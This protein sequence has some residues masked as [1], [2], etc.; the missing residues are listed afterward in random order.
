MI[1][2]L[3][4]VGLMTET[5]ILPLRKVDA[6]PVAEFLQRRFPDATVIVSAS[7]EAVAEISKV[8]EQLDTPMFPGRTP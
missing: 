2:A 7:A 4:T 5:A 3:L 8:V 6:V 1:A